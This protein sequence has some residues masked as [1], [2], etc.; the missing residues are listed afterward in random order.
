MKLS[1]AKWHRQHPHFLGRLDWSSAGHESESR[2]LRVPLADFLAARVERGPVWMGSP[3]I[4]A[5][6]PLL[7]ALSAPGTCW[8]CWRREGRILRGTIPRKPGHGPRGRLNAGGAVEP[9]SPGGSEFDAQ[10][11]PVPRRRRFT[12]RILGAWSPETRAQQKAPD[13]PRRAPKSKWN[14]R[15]LVD[16]WQLTSRME[17]RVD[18]SRN[19]LDRPPSAFRS[20]PIQQARFREQGLWS[21]LTIL[22]L[23]AGTVMASSETALG[24]MGSVSSASMEENSM[25]TPSL[26]V[27]NHWHGENMTMQD[28]STSELLRAERSPSGSSSIRR[29]SRRAGGG[30]RSRSCR[31]RSHPI[32]VRDLGLGYDSEEVVL[33]SQVVGL[34]DK[35]GGG[36]AYRLRQGD[37]PANCRVEGSA[38]E[39]EEAGRQVVRQA[40]AYLSAVRWTGIGKAAKLR[41]EPCAQPLHGDRRR[42]ALP[43]EK[44]RPPA[45]KR[46]PFSF[47]RAPPSSPHDAAAPL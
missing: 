22:S 40:D 32:N 47:L 30:G 3:W 1:P 13:L 14:L 31:L 36:G 35:G 15:H 23:F 9:P 21:I 34:R 12:A 29:S 16:C 28:L 43:S 44:D 18:G 10:E 8:P 20:L 24:S 4:G 5:A 38:S 2:R 46:R 33:F 27:W 41:A 42:V 26:A 6:L 37:R 45:L 17:W 39:E 7:R 25:E 11:G 19:R